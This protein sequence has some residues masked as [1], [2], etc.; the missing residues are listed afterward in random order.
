MA[1]QTFLLSF[2]IFFSSFVFTLFIFFSPGHQPEPP[3]TG[4]PTVRSAFRK[5][6]SADP[7][8][9]G[10]LLPLGVYYTAAGHVTADLNLSNTFI[11]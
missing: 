4:S 5:R 3:A 6:I 2:R 9:G 11:I 7:W 8:Q 1:C 10:A